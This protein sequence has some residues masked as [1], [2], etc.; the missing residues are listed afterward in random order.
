MRMRI[1]KNIAICCVSIISSNCGI[2]AWATQELET[3]SSESIAASAMQEAESTNT[4]GRCYAAVC[5]ALKP[6]SVRLYGASAYEARDLLLQDPRF[7]SIYIASK[8]QLQ[9]GDIIVFDRS[10]SHP[11]GHISVYQ[12]NLLEASDHVAP[13][14]K[15]QSYGG[16]SVFRLRGIYIA[17]A[18]MI[19]V[20]PSYT[21]QN[22]ASFSRQPPVQNY[23]QNEVVGSA[24]RYANDSYQPVNTNVEP[25]TP[26]LREMQTAFRSAGRTAQK[27]IR[28]SLAQRLTR[29]LLDN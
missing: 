7:T 28:T 6:L 27:R 22:S 15:T 18:S 17:D 16:T 1:W 10:P 11:D 12:G 24:K 13:V 14:T 23:G 26:T 9:R 5:R 20:A 25:P 3:L 19:P 8:D 21:M 4:T 2:I 29:F